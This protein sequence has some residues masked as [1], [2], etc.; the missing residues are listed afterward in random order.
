VDTTK[1]TK[2]RARPDQG[3]VDQARAIQ[4]DAGTP[5]AVEYMKSHGVEGSLIEQ[6]LAEELPAPGDRR[7]A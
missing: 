4:L 7:Q 2:N 3:T 5:S 6:V 1:K